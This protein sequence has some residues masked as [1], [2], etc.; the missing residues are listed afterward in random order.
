MFGCYRKGDANDPETYTAAITAVLAR[1]PEDVIQAVTHPATGL[2]SRLK[3]LPAVAEV[4]EA[5]EDL[6]Q[7][8]REREA[9]EKRVAKQ[10][11][12]R[13]Q[14]EERKPPR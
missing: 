9:Y 14:L 13:T 10:I 11:A 8:R 12:E 6:M 1:Y 4:R 5:C 2:V 3:F 7:P